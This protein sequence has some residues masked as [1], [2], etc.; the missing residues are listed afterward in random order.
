MEKRN[1]TRVDFA[2]CASVRHDNEVFFGGI[3]NMSLQGLFIKTDR[4][5]P[6]HDSVD[7][8]V[9]SSSNSSIDLRANV[10]RHEETGIGIQIN[11]IDVY[12]FVH[13]RDAVATQCNDQ[14]LL[15]CETYKMAS[16]IH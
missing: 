2:E 1:F 7:V 3:E 4:E 9:Y 8:T 10:V 16:C 14:N 13:L 12:S 15:L 6:L 5:I 11:K